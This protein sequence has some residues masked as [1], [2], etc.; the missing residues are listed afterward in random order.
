[1]HRRRSRNLRKRR[2]FQIEALESRRLLA[3]QLDYG[4][5]PDLGPGTG[6]GDYTTL[7]AYGGPSHEV[8]AALYMGTRPDGEVDPQPNSAADGDDYASGLFDDENGVSNPK[9][10][11][12]VTATSSPAVSVFVTNTTGQPATLYG[13]I[14]A[15]GDGVFDN[16]TERASK[17]VG[18]TGDSPVPTELQFSE[19]IPS[20]HGTTYARFRLG[21]TD[22]PAAANPTGAGGIGE[23]EDYQAHVTIPVRT[24]I[25][26][27]QRD[28]EINRFL[29]DNDFGES[30]AA[31]GD[32]DGNGAIDLAVGAPGDDT[33]GINRGA[34]HVL[35]RDEHG[36]VLRTDYLASGMSGLHELNDFDHFGSSISAV[37]DLDGNGVTDLIVGSPGD[38][39]GGGGV[40]AAYLLYLEVEDGRV[41]VDR[42]TRLASDV[43]G[44]ESLIDGRGFGSEVT[45]IGDLNDDQVMDLAIAQGREW[46]GG[47]CPCAAHATGRINSEHSRSASGRR[48]NSNAT[49]TW[50]SSLV[51]VGDVDGDG[52]PDLAVGDPFNSNGGT[53]DILF[54]QS[55]GTVR[56]VSRIG[57]G[58]SSRSAFGYSLAALGDVDGDEVP[59]LHVGS[60]GSSRTVLLSANG[61]VL[62]YDGGGLTSG[63]TEAVVSAGDPDGD[64]ALEIVVFQDGQLKSHRVSESIRS[65]EGQDRINDSRESFVFDTLSEGSEV[66]ALASIGNLDGIG[67]P[68]VAVGVPGYDALGVDAG[69][70]Q[71]VFRYQRGNQSAQL[72]ASNTGGMGPL[73][74]FDRFG[75][76]VA[77]AG[78]LDGDGF[79]DLY[80]TAPG[81]SSNRGT[82]YTLY[83]NS[84]GLVKEYVELDINT[85][86][87]AFSE[88]GL[89]LD[90]A[91]DMNGDGVT[92]LVVSSLTANRLQHQVQLLLMDA[93]LAGGRL[94][95]V[96]RPAGAGRKWGSQVAGL[97][98]VNGDQVPDLA[99]AD[100][101]SS[102]VDVLFMNQS[103][104][105]GSATMFQTVTSIPGGGS[106]LFGSSLAAMGDMDDD[107]IS[108][109][110][111]GS[112]NRVSVY[113]LNADGTV[114]YGQG[115]GRNSVYDDLDIPVSSLAALPGNADDN[116]VYLA[117]ASEEIYVDGLARALSRSHSVSNQPVRDIDADNFADS[118][119]TIGDLDGNGVVDV[120][121]GQPGSLHVLFMG[122]ATSSLGNNGLIE[123]VTEISVEE[124]SS[125]IARTVLRGGIDIDT[126]TSLGDVVSNIGDL[127]GDGLDDLAI[128]NGSR[129]DL[130][131][132]NSDGTV[133]STTPIE[134]GTTVGASP[135]SV[136]LTVTV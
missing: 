5:A 124:V 109:L 91:G 29:A 134:M 67:M 80:V 88:L 102:R 115:F 123:R 32:V 83:L 19:I 126:A 99:I 87:V 84:D 23:V 128:S 111:V 46:C 106:K 50:G 63:M 42:S 41:V 25:P 7:P 131:F 36:A 127:D 30:M 10:Q 69:A 73:R 35:L 72:I 17:D 3:A 112:A 45:A 113:F 86:G 120:V 89:S 85:N 31:I 98:D 62:Y 14:D 95:R 117:S 56:E 9:L 52:T 48:R 2:R 96:D 47:A 33:G 66:R 79:D 97:G 15:N 77:E 132:L 6:E 49:S 38:N 44:L 135:G 94:Q 76:A 75:F 107:G 116:Y 81:D 92:D 8:S 43:S 105:V 12:T 104:P 64:G 40:G 100:P 18:Y 11:L 39:T 129:V 59:D 22:D 101:Q 74:S 51:G 108:E 125:P 82:I 119:T 103:P 57:A 65:D 4:D 55:D 34:V 78:D 71:T 37:G 20:F 130:L 68:D 60:N 114:E 13:W 16:A 28:T 1:M 53:I 93:D 54:L 21:L 90:V 133:R 27:W 121:L 61:T 122:P 118:L 24:G 136:I 58:I 110:A 26:S 70:I